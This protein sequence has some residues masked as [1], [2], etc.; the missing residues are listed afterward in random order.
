M[1][2][3]RERKPD[4]AARGSCNY[5][6]YVSEMEELP[7]SGHFRKMDAGME[8]VN[9]I[10][11]GLPDCIVKKYTEYSG[12]ILEGD[13]I[14]IVFP[15]HMWGISLA[16]YS[17]LQHLKFRTGTYIYAVAVGESLSG[18]VDAT[19]CRR[20]KILEQFKRIFAKRGMGCDSDIFIRCIDMR[21]TMDRSEELVRKSTDDR[22]NIKCI[23]RGLLFHSVDELISCGQSVEK[24]EAGNAHTAIQD[25]V[26][27][28]R[29]GRYAEIKRYSEQTDNIRLSNIYLDEEIF[30]GVKLCRVI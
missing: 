13:S 20:I 26:M 16:V 21:R 5:I 27:G 14:G 4:S 6:F 28:R 22:A 3:M 17:F 15:A 24:T 23:L 25:S 1:L 19:A 18:G 2:D 30:A 9:Q 12:E 11:R 10:E 29:S 8:I 7:A